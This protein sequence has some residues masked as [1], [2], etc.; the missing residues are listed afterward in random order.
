M[1]R[2]DKGP[3][4]FAHMAAPVPEGSFNI[5]RYGGAVE[6]TP[7]PFADFFMLE[8]PL[9]AG[10]VLERREGATIQSDRET[11]L[12]LPPH[13]RFSS[14]WR[15]GCLQL[16]LRVR[17][18]AV[19]RR[20]QFLI[21]DP[22]ATLPRVPPKIDLKR[23]EGWRIRGLM[24]LM[25]QEFDLAVTART[26]RM[27]ATTL[28]AALIDAVLT[29]YRDKVENAGLAEAHR[30]LPAQLRR[31]VKYIEDN[32]SGDLSVPRLVAQTGCSER[33]LFNQF[34]HFLGTTP[35]AHVEQ[36]RLRYSRTLLLT[37][38]FSVADAARQAGFSHMGRFARLYRECYGEAPSQ[39]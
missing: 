15:A 6:I 28:S 2:L 33:T 16:M 19:L 31:C 13:V 20:W 22:M 12:F 34:Q 21:G 37:G 38:T 5:L 11:A 7:E 26:G 1:R 36:R 32:L 18:A 39:T 25:R 30:V 29:Y 8:L 35:R 4:D 17:S 10:V 3:F 9:S 24:R 27:T 14:T 23:P